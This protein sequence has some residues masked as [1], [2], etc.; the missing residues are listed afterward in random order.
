MVLPNPFTPHRPLF[1]MAWSTSDARP[2]S[3]ADL[4]PLFRALRPLGVI[5]QLQLVMLLAL[6]PLCW[7][8]GAGLTVLAL[9]AAYASLCPA[10][11]MQ[12]LQYSTAFYVAFGAMAVLLWTD[13]RMNDALFKWNGM[14]A[15][16]RAVRITAMRW[17]R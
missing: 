11:V 2:A 6:W 4:E 3:D 1:R 7:I 17:R 15:F 8:L 9:F 16:N 14:E 5:C 10:A 13:G 12:S